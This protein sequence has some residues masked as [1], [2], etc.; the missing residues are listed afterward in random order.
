MTPTESLD[1]A[2]WRMSD[3]MRSMFARRLQ[4]FGLTPPLVFVLKL[5]DQ[6]RPMRYLADELLFDPS[7]VTS[8]VDALETKGLAERRADPT[9]RRVKLIALT[10]AGADVRE[11]LHVGMCT[12][13]PGFETLTDDDR[14]AL[15][16]L[17]MKAVA[18]AEE[19]ATAPPIAS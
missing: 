5:L 10:P 1:D 7:Y 6:P 14:V 18:T 16:T 17:L 15:A 9:D 2:M 12:G 19:S 8:L 3:V 11:Q 4:A 13:L